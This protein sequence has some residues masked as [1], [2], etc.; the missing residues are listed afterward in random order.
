[1]TWSGKLL[2]VYT[3]VYILCEAQ[4]AHTHTVTRRH[5]HAH[6]HTPPPHTLTHTHTHARTHAHTHTRTHTHTH[7]H[8]HI[9][10]H[11]DLPI[12]FCSVAVLWFEKPF[13]D[14]SGLFCAFFDC[15]CVDS[16]WRLFSLGWHPLSFW[17]SSYDCCNQ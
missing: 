11:Y 5:T 1:M 15:P 2:I 16:N 3:H 10:A 12:V 13:P 17:P 14:V 4:C 9:H 7:A 8:T 6:T